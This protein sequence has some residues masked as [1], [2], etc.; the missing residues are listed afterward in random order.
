[1]KK[2][3]I[4]AVLA[5]MVASFGKKKSTLPS[6]RG[7]IEALHCIKGRIRF[8]IPSLKGKEDEA[9]VKIKE[10]RKIEAIDKVEF[11]SVTG[12]LLVIF[13][14]QL[15]QKTSALVKFI[16]FALNDLFNNIFGL[17]FNFFAIDHLLTI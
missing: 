1:M 12:S 17:A 6:F 2:F 9:L 15:L 4:L 13:D 8:A 5:Q 10:L 14:E 3:L 11:S 16:D 7:V